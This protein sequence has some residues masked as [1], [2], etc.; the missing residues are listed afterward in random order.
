MPA[1][2]NLTHFRTVC[3]YML[4]GVRRSVPPR[5][6]GRAI[7]GDAKPGRHRNALIGHRA[8]GFPAGKARP[9]PA[10][11]RFTAVPRLAA[12]LRGWPRFETKQLRRN[13]SFGIRLLLGLRLFLELF[14]FS[15]GHLAF[16]QEVALLVDAGLES[17]L[18]F[19]GIL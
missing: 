10:A 9:K 11:K 13:L 5:T 6:A 8:Y 1:Q 19:H 7:P 14:E 4:R 2:F 3:R 12:L 18:R 17:L 15:P 16:P